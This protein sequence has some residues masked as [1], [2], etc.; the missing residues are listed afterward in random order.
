MTAWDGLELLVYCGGLCY[1]CVFVAMI[2]GLS[3]TAQQFR[4][5]SPE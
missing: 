2:L 1:G 4:C 5:D 3:L